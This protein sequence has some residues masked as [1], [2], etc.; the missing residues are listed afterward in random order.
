M[1]HTW[2]TASATP[3][4]ALQR[5][6]EGNRRFRKAKGKSSA[7]SWSRHLAVQAQRPFA[8]IL[9][10]SDSRTP[11][12]ILF[13]E[14]FGDLFVIRIAGN[15]VAPSVVGS[16]EFAASQFG[17]RLVVVM[18][19][20]RCGAIA[21]TV[22]AIETGLGPE[23]KNIRAIT[24]R[25]A[26]HIQSLVRPGNPKT[27]LREAMRANVRASVDHLRHGSRLIEELVVA[28]RVAV[29]GAEYELETGAVHLL[30][31]LPA[32]ATPPQAPQEAGRLRVQVKRIYEPA[33]VGD[34]YRVLVDRLWPRGISKQRAH[35]DAWLRELAPS[36]ALR[37][38]YG[39]RPTRWKEFQRRYGGEL[40]DQKPALQRLVA[41]AQKGPLTLLYASRETERN[42][43]TALKLH[44][45]GRLS[46]RR[47]P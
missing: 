21:A 12:E 37:R 8:I 47:A 11:V 6:V 24:D 32:L 15:I 5:L 36:D 2:D 3:E 20:N 29:V 16:I 30:D 14:G 28:G 26:P 27:L 19:H 22:K 31:S 13:D 46:T 40:E 10:C 23:S 43:A 45:E 4:A 25:I 33:A 18:G 39:H 35:L 7:R 41:E 34:G 17:S 44:L 38:W 42:N 1:P 9:G